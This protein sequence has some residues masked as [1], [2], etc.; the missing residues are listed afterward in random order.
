MSSRRHLYAL[1]KEGCACGSGQRRDQSG[2]CAAAFPIAVNGMDAEEKK[3]SCGQPHRISQPRGWSEPEA[4][5][6]AGDS[7]GFS[8]RTERE[9][10]HRPAHG[11]A[12]DGPQRKALGDLVQQHRGRNGISRRG[13]IL[14]CHPYSDQPPAIQQSM[15]RGGGEQRPGEPMEFG[16]AALMI[17]IICAG[18]AD[19]VHEPI[20][21]HESQI[22]SADQQ[23]A[24]GT[25]D[26]TNQ[27]RD[28]AK[29]GDTGQQTSA[30]RYQGVGKTAAAQ[31]R[32][33]GR[34]RR[35]RHD[36]RQNR[37]I[38]GSAEEFGNQIIL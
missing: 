24:A 32:D 8:Q 17:V 14:G 6:P 4:N 19:R 36:G 22:S 13:Q 12:D 2:G 31:Q 11:S 27:L 9:R 23:D 37:Q 38:Q 16:R 33:T 5:R 34:G 7:S 10:H 3:C 21:G 29:S 28:Q 1:L 20:K 15:N 25:A 26:F 18:R 35:N 30:K